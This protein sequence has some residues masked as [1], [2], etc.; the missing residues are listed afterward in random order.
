MIK[1]KE[2]K[3]MLFCINCNKESPHTVYYVGNYLKSV[4]CD[5]C[6]K[7]IE[8]DRQ[9]LRT[10]FAED[11]ID[12]VLTKPRRMTDD[13]RK[14]FATLLPFFPR[15]LFE[16]PLEVFKEMYGVLKKEDGD[17]SKKSSNKGNRKISNRKSISK[18]CNNRNGSN[19]SIGKEGST[20]K[21]K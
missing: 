18:K 12:R 14:A 17:S 2:T 6:N 5:S 7:K 10:V 11:F 20:K 16:E 21:Y 9:H 4:V 19:K 8:I 3:I 13:M 1:D 15:R